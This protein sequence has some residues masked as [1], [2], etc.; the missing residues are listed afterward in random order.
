M[1]KQRRKSSAKGKRAKGGGAAPKTQAD[2]A[3]PI[4]SVAHFERIVGGDKPVVI[5]FWAPWCAP[6]RAMAP[7][8]DAVAKEFVDRVH[9]VKVDTQALPKLGQA[10]NVRSIPALVVLNEGEVVDSTVGLSAEGT[11]RRMAQRALNQAEGVGLGDRLRRWF[12]GGA[13]SPA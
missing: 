6:C 4:R 13:P 12:G 7:A 9:F 1:A 2:G 8:F 11:L 3:V 5:D 10:F